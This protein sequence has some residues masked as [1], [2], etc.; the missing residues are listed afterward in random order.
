VSRIEAA[1]AQRLETLTGQEAGCCVADL[2]KDAKALRAS[3][4]FQTALLR[5]KALGDE[6]RFTILALLEK[7]GEMC[8]CEMQAALGLTHATVSHHMTVLCEA[9]LIDCEKR[10]KW[11]HYS[12]TSIAKKV[13]P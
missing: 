8:A 13:L 7:R 3:D 6:N 5:A 11:A 10:G 1:L 4:A 9:G 2:A 12:L